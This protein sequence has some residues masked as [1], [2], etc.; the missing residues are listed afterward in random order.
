MRDWAWLL[1]C[2]VWKYFFE[3][4][5]RERVL[6]DGQT[7]FLIRLDEEFALVYHPQ[8]KQNNGAPI[9]LEVNESTL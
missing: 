7:R 9:S 4:F 2:W 1:P 3:Q 5:P 8:L 6:V